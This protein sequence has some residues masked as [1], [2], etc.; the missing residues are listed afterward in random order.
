MAEQKIERLLKELSDV[1]DAK[2]HQEMLLQSIISEN[3]IVVNQ[4]G[5]QVEELKLENQRLSEEKNHRV[6][7]LQVSTQEFYQKL[8]EINEKNRVLEAELL[9][10]DESNQQELSEM[11][12]MISRLKHEVIEEANL[13]IKRRRDEMKEEERSFKKELHQEASRLLNE[14]SDFK[15][16]FI[17]SVSVDDV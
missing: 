4:L 10:K 16:K 1:N 7:E 9:A 15:T 8:S 6:Q 3:K 11:M 14:V 12:L 17:E 2:Q 5:Q 13:E